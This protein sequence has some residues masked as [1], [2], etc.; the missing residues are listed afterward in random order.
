MGAARLTDGVHEVA[1]C[2]LAVQ[3]QGTSAVGDGGDGKAG[4]MYLVSLRW[5]TAWE[6]Y[7]AHER[8]ASAR[9]PTGKRP[10]QTG[11]PPPQPGP[12]DNSPLLTE[13]GS[14]EGH[15][16]VLKADLKEGIDYKVI[17][18]EVSRLHLTMIQF[19]AWNIGP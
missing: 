5:W 11:H 19:Q 18:K 16:A 9:P 3:E 13:S 6:R 12:I 15:D 10:L 14:K 2:S 4:H 8:E 17:S 7:T 1:D